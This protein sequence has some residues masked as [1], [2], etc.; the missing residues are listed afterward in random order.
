MKTAEPAA[1]ARRPRSTWTVS[2]LVHQHLI[3]GV[4]IGSKVP[5]DKVSGEVGGVFAVCRPVIPNLGCLWCNGVISAA[6][7]QEEA[8]NSKEQLA[9]AYGRL[10]HSRRARGDSVRLPTP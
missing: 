7:L 3:P 5:V 2:A 6:R 10:S 9:W 1:K 4:Q 8:A